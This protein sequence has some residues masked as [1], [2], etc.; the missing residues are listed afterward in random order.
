M[1]A[2]LQACLACAIALA[3]AECCQA[4]IARGHY[5]GTAGIAA[6][7]A[8]HD[9]QQA[10]FDGAIEIVFRHRGGDRVRGHAAPLV[11]AADGTGRSHVRRQLWRSGFIRP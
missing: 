8:G 6:V 5:A 2:A 11:A 1:R 7:F 9:F 3:R 4:V 10:K